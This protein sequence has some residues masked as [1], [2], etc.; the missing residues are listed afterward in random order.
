MQIVLRAGAAAFTW[1]TSYDEALHD[2][3][4]GMLLLEDYTAA[5]LN[6]ASVAYVDSCAYDDSSYMAAWTERQKIA[7]LWFDARRGASWRFAVLS[8]LQK[9]YLALRATAKSAYHARPWK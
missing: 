7:S 2:V 1:K 9:A 5:F 4:P 6:D 8:R 3:S